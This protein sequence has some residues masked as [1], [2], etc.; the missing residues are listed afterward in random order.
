MFPIEIRY[1]SVNSYSRQVWEAADKY[2]QLCN[3]D[4]S[5]LRKR[6]LYDEH[7]NQY[8]GDRYML[9]VRNMV[10]EIAWKIY[11]DDM[12][13]TRDDNRLWSLKKNLVILGF[14]VY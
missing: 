4:I 7:L 2:D 8:I 1:G 11:L 10:K 3:A 5:V 6:F 9:V 12:E 14:Y 13:N